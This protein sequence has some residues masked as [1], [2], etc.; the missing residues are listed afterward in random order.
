MVAFQH[1]PLYQSLDLISSKFEEHQNLI[2]TSPTGSGK[3]ILIPYLA[4]KKYKGR[5]VVL[6]PRKIAA[7]SLAEYLSSLLKE[8]CGET[9]GYQF[10]LENCNLQKRV[11][12]FKPSSFLQELLHGDLL[13]LHHFDEFHERVQRWIC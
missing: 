13:R 7:Q 11:F 2:L 6:E 12:Y 10:H 8:P 3:S 4:S 9:V 1:L 5:V